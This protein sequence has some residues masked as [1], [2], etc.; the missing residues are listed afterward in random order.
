M[1]ERGEAADARQ[2]DVGG[3]GV[4]ERGEGDGMGQGGVQI[5]D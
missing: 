3:E 1:A 5:H 2:S 4:V